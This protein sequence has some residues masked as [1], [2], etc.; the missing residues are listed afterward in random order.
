[1]KF[2]WIAEPPFNYL[3]GGDLTGYDVELARQIA[4]RMGV[5]F[6]PVETSFADLLPGLDDGRWDMTTGM[7]V[8]EERGRRAS[9]TMPIWALHDGLLVRES[10]RDQIAG[11]RSLAD[12]NGK[13]A[14]LTGQ[15]QEQTAL[16]LGVGAHNIVAFQDY[17][18]AAQAVIDGTVD[19]YASVELAHQAHIARHPG[20]GLVSV[21]V[22]AAEKEPASGAFACRQRETRDQ[23][24]AELAGFIGTPEHA[25][26]L[27][28]FGLA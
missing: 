1:M 7:F 19:A 17:R 25:A 13:L 5:P 28:Q 4:S 9:F 24:N 20:S 15:I 2:G 18:D 6:E 27:A 23:I 16:G 10:S 26:L 3:E 14:V 8:T 22:P 12:G 21:G 11:Y